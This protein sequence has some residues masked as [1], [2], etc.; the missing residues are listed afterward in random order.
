MKDT[1]ES[2][3]KLIPV[4][5]II[6]AAQ[7][8]KGVAY[9]TPFM[10]S[11][12]LSDKYQANIYL[13][14]EDLQVVRSYKLRGA[15]NKISSLDT[16]TLSNG[17]VCASAGNHAQGVA[18]ACNKLGIKGI[19]FM[20]NPTPKQKVKQ[21]KMFGKDSVQIQ[22]VGDTFDDAYVKA[23]AFCKEQNAQFIPPFDDEKIIEGQGTVGYEILLDT[24]V[25]LDYVFVPIGGGGLSAGLGSYFKQVSPH[26]KII[27]LEPE[28]APA[29]IKSLE[30][31]ELV[32]LDKIDKFIDGAAVKRVGE[33]NFEICSQVL[34]DVTTIS[35]GK[36]CDTILK[37]Y[38]E[39]A[40]VVEPAGAMSVAALDF[41]KDKIKGKN[42]CCVISG[43]NNDITRMEEIKER[44]LLYKGLKHYF[45]IRF[46]QRAGAL[47]EFVAEVLGP[48][49]DITHFEYTKKN[50]RERGP[51]MVGIEL[52]SAEDYEGLIGRLDAHHIAYQ[53]LNDKFEFFHFLI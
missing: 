53:V 27:G 11:I 2:D 32:T 48:N 19:I 22:L 35:E 4:E 30:Q 8:I 52:Q 21:V 1:V 16:S 9:H 47:K 18:Y 45:I 3:K 12:N 50:N 26:T 24:E 15:Y 25:P 38:D 10:H 23:Q 34:D 29:M 28:G 33:L 51:A 13:K 43:G 36:V 42:V 7:R 6:N 44:A 46:P 14:R 41:Y 31:G 49:D 5:N 37:L 17:V 39:E 20:P 40:I